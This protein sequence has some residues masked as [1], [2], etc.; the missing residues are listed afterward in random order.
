MKGRA[1]R[2]CERSLSERSHRE[3]CRRRNLTSD[4]T[5]GGGGGSR[6]SPHR[7][8]TDLPGIAV[9]LPNRSPG[10]GAD[11]DAAARWDRGAIASERGSIRRIEHLRGNRTWPLQMRLVLSLSAQ[12]RV[13]EASHLETREHTKDG[14]SSRTWIVALVPVMR[15]RKISSDTI[16][17][18]IPLESRNNSNSFESTPFALPVRSRCSG[19]ARRTFQLFRPDS[20]DERSGG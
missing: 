16:S 20:C 11:G 19:Q 17:R 6:G 14:I 3:R 4:T 10:R 7:R 18:D 8:C 5:D 15:Y 12:Q 9:E 2:D 13:F 1:H